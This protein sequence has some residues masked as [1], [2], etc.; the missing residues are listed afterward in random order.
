[1][2][3][4]Q[5]F[6]SYKEVSLSQELPV[7]YQWAWYF[8]IELLSATWLAFPY[9]ML[10]ER[11]SRASTMSNSANPMSTCMLT[12]TAMVDNL[13]EKVNNILNWAPY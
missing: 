9:C 8:V 12:L 13:A 11:L 4:Y 1:M 2:I 3:R 5:H 6:V 10:A 7:Y